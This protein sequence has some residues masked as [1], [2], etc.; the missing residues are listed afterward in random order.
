MEPLSN[1]QDSE[2]VNPQA[3][4]CAECVCYPDWATASNSL[5]PASGSSP[6]LVPCS[7]GAT[8]QLQHLSGNTRTPRATTRHQLLF[9]FSIS[10]KSLITLYGWFLLFRHS[11]GYFLFLPAASSVDCPQTG[12][13]PERPHSLLSVLLWGQA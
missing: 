6:E 9:S 12:P 8:N 5:F 7:R 4:A 1:T 10:L 11:G 2:R 13:L 3:P